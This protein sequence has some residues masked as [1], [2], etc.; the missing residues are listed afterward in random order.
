MRSDLVSG[1]VAHGAIVEFSLN[2][3]SRAS[4]PVHRVDLEGYQRVGS[5]NSNRPTTERLSP[6]PG[7]RERADCELLPSSAEMCATAKANVRPL[8]PR[9][10]RPKL[11]LRTGAG[12]GPPTDKNRLPRDGPKDRV[13]TASPSLAK[14]AKELA[15][16]PTGRRCSV[17]RSDSGGDR[18]SA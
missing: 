14:L 16:R 2:P 8:E 9:P 5:R 1:T 11:H 12:A 13:R 18:Y 17:L 4:P 10:A 7:G 3:L 6:G 15:L